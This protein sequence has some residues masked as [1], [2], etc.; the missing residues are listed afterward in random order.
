MKAMAIFTAAAAVLALGACDRLGIGGGNA[1]SNASA[2]ASTNASEENK[3]GG[4]GNAQADAGIGGK[5]P[6]SGGAIP[7]GAGGVNLDRAYVMGRWTDDGDCAAAVEFMEDGRFVASN[8]NEGLWHLAG[9]RLTMQGERAL[10]LQIVPIDQ[11]TMNVVNPD[12]SLG[13]ST[14]C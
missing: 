7:A 1:A 14:R 8:G 6:A 12:G 11:N 9:D 13:R 4:G 3:D 2:N 5:D 10:V